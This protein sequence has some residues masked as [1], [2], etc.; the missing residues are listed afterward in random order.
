MKA[1]DVA[2]KF[3][4]DS[5]PISCE[6]YG[7]GHINDT[8]CVVCQPQDGDAI[9]FILQGLSLTAFPRPDQLMANFIGI[10]TYLRE[11]IVATGGDPARETLSLV[12]TKDGKDYYR[13]LYQIK[14]YYHLMISKNFCECFL[15]Q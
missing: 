4:I 6:E 8:Y 3:L 2:K 9:R 13:F 10:T 1:I 15:I 14:T 5:L 12:K 7:C 11:K